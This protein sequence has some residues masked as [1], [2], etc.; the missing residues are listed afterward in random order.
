MKIKE[1]LLKYSV[2]ASIYA[3]SASAIFAQTPTPEID[4]SSPIPEVQGIGANDLIRWIFTIFMVVAV[5]AA[6]I[7]LIIGGLKWILSGGEKEKIEEAR[8]QIVAALVGLIIVIL[9]FV[10]LNFVLSLFG[11]S[12]GGLNLP[13]IRE[14]GQGESPF[15]PPTPTP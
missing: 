2:I 14:A 6:L 4:I 15:V 7:W 1:N 5:L 13:T 3:S 10:I 9:T 12:I 8:K 11:I